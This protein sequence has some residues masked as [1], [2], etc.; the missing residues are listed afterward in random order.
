MIDLAF[1]CYNRVEYT[2]LALQSILDDPSQSFRLTIWDNASS[3]GTREYLRSLSDPRIEDLVL[4]DE[5]V[6]QVQ[7]VNT[8]FERTDGEL[9]GKLD[10]DCIMTPGWA[11]TLKQ[12]HEDIPELGVVACWHFFEDD[13]DEE[14]ARHKI[15]TFG[16]HRILRHPWTCGTGLLFKRET[17]RELGPIVGPGTTG[18]WTRMAQ[19]GYVNGFYYPL[20]YQ[21]HMDDPKSEHSVLKSE[22]AFQEAKSVTFT[23]NLNETGTASLKNFMERRER[24]ISNLLDDPWDVKHYVGWRKTLKGLKRR[25]TGGPRGS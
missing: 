23:L 6:G 17:Y 2:R 20:I 3:D 18:Y 21:E 12:A 25:L 1:I 14:R 22:E 24:I 4:S 10:N 16:R 19:A 7:A 9:L 5:N 13:F 15:Q 11:D 8:V